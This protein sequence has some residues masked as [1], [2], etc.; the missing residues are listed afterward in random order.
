MEKGGVA[1]RAVYV[2]LCMLLFSAIGILSP[3]FAQSPPPGAKVAPLPKYHVGDQWVMDWEGT[4]RKPK[5]IKVTEKGHVKEN[6]DGQQRFFD[7]GHNLI[8]RGSD[9]RIM[10]NAS[11]KIRGFPYWVGKKW[12]SNSFFMNNSGRE[13][14]YSSNFVVEALE[15]VTVPAGKFMAYKI[16]EE[17]TYDHSQRTL[18]IVRWYS[19]K[20]KS[21]IKRIGDL[22]LNYVLKSY[23]VK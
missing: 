12:K 2:C 3:T 10:S 9:G 15:E 14:S 1:M 7:K 11:V 17:R 20:T 4:L 21:H 23:Q 6:E 16:S 8:G 19:P 5:V 22:R 13:I 18:S